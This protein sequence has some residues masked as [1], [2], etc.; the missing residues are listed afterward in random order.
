MN[1]LV[2]DSCVVAKWILPETDSLQAQRLVTDAGTS[3]MKLVVLDLAFAEVS[4]AIWK[5]HRQKGI[6][7]E[8]ARELVRE[9]EAL[10]SLPLQIEISQK[11][12]RPAF[13]IA[14]QYGRSMYDALFLALMQERGSRGVTA[15]EPLYNTT[16][17]D[18]P[19][20]ILLRNLQ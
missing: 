6:S 15:D 20:L 12:I 17:A 14:T 9:L 18:F 5:R 3:S 2:V 1:E 10:H 7:L 19:N 13:E 11:F 4:N 16:H 8:R